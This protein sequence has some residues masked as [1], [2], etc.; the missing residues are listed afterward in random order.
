MLILTGAAI[1]WRSKK[2]TTV[3]LS[4]RDAEYLAASIIVKEVIWL[5]R[6]HSDMLNLENSKCIE[7]RNDNSDAITTARNAV[8]NQRSK[9]TD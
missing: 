3:A 1:S 7:L 9:H 6:L 4:A 5:S 2:Q 8:I